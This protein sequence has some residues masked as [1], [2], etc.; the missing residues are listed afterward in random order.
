M[1]NTPMILSFL[2]TGRYEAVKYKLHN[3]VHETQ[4]FVEALCAFYPQHR[5]HVVMTGEAY[6]KHNE[7][8]QQVC[9]YD[10]ISIPSGKNEDELWMMFTALADA[11]PEQAQLIVDVTHGFRSQPMLALATCI[12][13]RTAK[14]VDIQG[15][16]YGAFDAR[17]ENNIA[18]VFD[19]TPFLDLI[20]WSVSAQQFVRYGNAIPMRDLLQGIHKQTYAEQAAYKARKLSSVGERLADLSNAL[21]LVRPSEVLERAEEVASAIHEAQEDL[22]HVMKTKPFSLLLEKITEHTQPF[23]YAQSELFSEDGLAAQS[24]MLR[25][26]IETEQYT[27][28][29]T[30]ARELLISKVCFLDNLDPH[31]QRSQAE[32]KLF[33]LK[34]T[35]QAGGNLKAE[36]RALTQL[37]DSVSHLRN[38]INHAGMRLKPISAKKAIQNIQEVCQKVAAL[39]TR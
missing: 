6:A 35:L 31:K 15:I 17:D 9:S 37:W 5:A 26:Y 3:Q 19:L 23:A 2:G 10:V 29:V 22:Q 36:E 18:P 28:A 16:F 38:D 11:I 39:I 34:Q 12:Y 21:A 7:A 24:D 25:F 33:Q 1:A 8:L 14:N 4:F 32:G 30:L 13:L 27:Q 20:D